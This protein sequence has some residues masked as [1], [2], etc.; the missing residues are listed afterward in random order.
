[1]TTNKKHKSLGKALETILNER[2]PVVPNGTFIRVLEKYQK[3]VTKN[4]MKETI[5][6]D[7]RSNMD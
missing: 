2:I 3:K 6:Y 7:R 4:E 1:M 5:N